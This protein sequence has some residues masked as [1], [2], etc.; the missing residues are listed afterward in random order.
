MRPEILV[1]AL[2]LAASTA[3]AAPLESAAH[4][5][6]AIRAKLGNPTAEVM[7]NGGKMMPAC[8]AALS[9]TL[10]PSTNPG[11]RTASVT[12]PA[13]A[14]TVFAGV[15]QV[16]QISAL[17]ATRAISP[18]DT[19]DATDTET[20]PVPAGDLHGTALTPASL[21]EGLRARQ[22][23]PA[24][25]ALTETMTDLQTAV[26]SGQQVALRVRQGGL[27][28]STEGIVLQ[29]GAVGDMVE[30]ENATSHR[31]F[32]AAVVRSLPAASG[33]YAVIPDLSGG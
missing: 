22:A 20:R 8:T 18:G 10:L 7:P 33:V 28:I 19:I 5:T 27:V 16:R 25:A 15:R 23:I 9:V 31:K 17:V 24:G 30:V 12:C 2:M 14:W 3:R 11:F 32:R 13:P 26:R 21:G 4:V 6:D 1:T 29:N